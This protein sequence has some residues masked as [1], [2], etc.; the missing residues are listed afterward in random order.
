MMFK[1]DEK[2]NSNLFKLIQ[3]LNSYYSSKRSHSTY[4]IL[5]NNYGKLI[6][7]I[8]N[9]RYKEKVENLPFEMNIKINREMINEFNTLPN[10]EQKNIISLAWFILYCRKFQPH[11]HNC[12][13]HYTELIKQIKSLP[14]E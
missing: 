1:L 11:S 6:R 2:Q 8:G 5:M 12:W 7:K 10:W 9:E 4:Q 3:F 14:T 13:K